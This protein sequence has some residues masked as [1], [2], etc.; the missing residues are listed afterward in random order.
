MYRLT[1]SKGLGKNILEL[2]FFVPKCEKIIDNGIQ[3]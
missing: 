1:E 2:T 3:L